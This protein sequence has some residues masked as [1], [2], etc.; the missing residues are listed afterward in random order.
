MNGLLC[1]D[2]IMFGFVIYFIMA[3]LQQQMTRY[4]EDMRPRYSNPT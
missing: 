1:I 2:V 3:L 4:Y